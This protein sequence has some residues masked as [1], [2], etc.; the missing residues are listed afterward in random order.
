MEKKRNLI[1]K[2]RH[3]VKEIVQFILNPRLLLCLG[4]AWIITNGWSYILIAIGTACD[5]PWMIAVSGAY[6]AFL[7]FPFTPEKILT[8]IIAMFLLRKLFPNDV[9]TLKK[10][11]D[12]RAK[13]HAE[14][15]DWRARR[16]AKR[17]EKKLAR[18]NAEEDFALEDKII[19]DK[20]EHEVEE[21][22]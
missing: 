22:A 11:R 9:K 17:A 21:E 4:I 16:K 13:Y 12:L 20:S 5:I 7:W 6:M 18:E 2:I 19:N 10:L 8:V 1:K 3:W 14:W 15:V